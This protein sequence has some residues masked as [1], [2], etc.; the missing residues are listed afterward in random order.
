MSEE[1][2]KNAQDVELSPEDLEK[3]AGGLVVDC[4]TWRYARVVDEKTGEVIG[5]NWYIKDAQ[6]LAE[7]NGLSTEVITMEEYKK[8]FGHDLKL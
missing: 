2:K 6:K 8:R 3:I 5:Q 4:G 1:I 7:R